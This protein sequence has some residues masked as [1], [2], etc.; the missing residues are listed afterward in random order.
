MGYLRLNNIYLYDWVFL[1]IMINLNGHYFGLI[2]LI[3]ILGV[4]APLAYSQDNSIIELYAVPGEMG[5]IDSGLV[6]LPNTKIL[7]HTQTSLMNPFGTFIILNDDDVTTTNSVVFFAK[8][9]LVRF[10]CCFKYPTWHI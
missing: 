9:Q 6:T 3:V 2:T 1:N 4:T 8:S 10:F 5:V 7:I